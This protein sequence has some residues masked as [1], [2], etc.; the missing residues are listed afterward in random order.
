MHLK[1]ACCALLLAPV[2]ALASPQCQHSESR[3][4]KLDLAGAKAVVFEVNSHN[5]RLQA[6]PGAAPALNGRACASSAD[7]LGQ[8]QLTQEKVGDKLVVRLQ[9]ETN[10]LN[11]G[12]GNRYAYLDLSGSVPDNIL[13]QLKVGSGDASVAGAHSL[14]ADI[15][16]GDVDARG[17]KGRVTAAVGS[18]DLALSDVG[19][20]HVLSIGSGDVKARGI[21][22]D[23]EVGSIGSGDLE[24]QGVRGNVK[25]GS[26]G[27]GDADLVDVGGNVSLESIGSGDFDVRN[28]GGDLR[29]GRRGSGSIDHSGVAGQ[30]ELPR[31]R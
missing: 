14:S 9:R 18:G 10:A 15:G 3:E 8:L 17:I 2:A 22:G 20:L 24:L 16:S 21:R 28:V 12:R 1:L 19:D 6:S 26:I 25:I 31:R 4:L 13:V 5:L 30:V 27:S 23:A 29:V 11:I 7:L